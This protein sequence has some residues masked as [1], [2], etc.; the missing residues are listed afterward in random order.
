[1]RRQLY[2]LPMVQLCAVGLCA[3]GCEDT[4]SAA[5]FV[6][7]S[8]F[9][10]ALPSS[11][12][13]TL[14]VA[15]L[16]DDWGGP[17]PVPDEY[18]LVDLL[19]LS[20]EVANSLNNIT[21]SCLSFVDAVAATSPS[22]R[23]AT[24]RRWGPVDVD[25]ATLALAMTRT[26]DRYSWTF[27]AAR[28]QTERLPTVCSGAHEPGTGSLSEGRGVLDVWIDNWS[29]LDTVG[30]LKTQYD[31]TDGQELRIEIEGL[32]EEGGRVENGAYYFR[33]FLSGGGDFQ[34][35]TTALIDDRLE[36]V[37]EVRTRW[38]ADGQGRSD[39]WVIID[40]SSREYHFRECF[41]GRDKVWM[42]NDYT[43]SERGSEDNCVYP[44][45][46]DVDQI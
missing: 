12:D 33:K 44:S 13:H 32:G 41:D 16:A 39:A 6:P 43:G 4:L 22:Y 38:T 31:L 8:E 3:V 35:R 20:L 1:M 45:S 37:L 14:S 7:D 2:I 29:E 40:D 19:K 15:R 30:T 17:D 25:E 18:D 26:Q 5:P 10:E 27:Q 34:Y 21:L 11:E 9:I 23:S 28:A 46:A 36:A 24:Q 42:T